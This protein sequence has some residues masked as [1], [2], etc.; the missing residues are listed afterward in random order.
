[1]LEQ[2]AVKKAKKKSQRREALAFKIH[3]LFSGAQ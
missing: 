1:M 2:V 3:I